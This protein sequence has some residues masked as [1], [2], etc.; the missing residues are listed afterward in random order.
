MGAKD[1]R[2][3]ALDGAMRV[4]RALPSSLRRS[5]LYRTNDLF[6]AGAVGLLRDEAERVLLVKHRF[7]V[8]FPWGLPGG[9]IA[10]DESFA[11]GLSRELKEEL[12]I[13]AEIDAE[14]FDTE[15]NL[16]GRYI[17]VTLLARAP[18]TPLRLSGEILEG[19]FVTPAEIPAETYPLHAA[20]IRRYWAS[21]RGAAKET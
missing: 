11:E 8:P 13:V 3:R 10:H 5:Y 18:G 16:S 19:A 21:L 1:L 17:S 12:G 9:F 7:R 20:L 14:V 2:E 4:W 6:L 15:L